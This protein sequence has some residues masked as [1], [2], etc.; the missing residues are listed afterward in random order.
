MNVLVFVSI[1]NAF[2]SS[3]LHAHSRSPP[4]TQPHPPPYLTVNVSEAQIR[5]EVAHLQLARESKIVVNDIDTLYPVGP[6]RHLSL[7]QNTELEL[8]RVREEYEQR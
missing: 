1:T 2:L 6:L 7:P 8:K 3:L 5:L 4:T